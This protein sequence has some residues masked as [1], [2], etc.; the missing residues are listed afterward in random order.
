MEKTFKFDDE[1]T[2]NRLGYGTMQ[3]TGDGVWGPVADPDNALLNAS[4]HFL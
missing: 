1:L 3:L 2:V 4:S